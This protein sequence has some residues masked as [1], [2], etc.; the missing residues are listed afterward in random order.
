MLFGE[1]S[2]FHSS[3][4]LAAFPQPRFFSTLKKYDSVIRYK[5]LKTP[6]LRDA[7]GREL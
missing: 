1:T 5:P 4:A 6:T 7:A 2:L 3:T